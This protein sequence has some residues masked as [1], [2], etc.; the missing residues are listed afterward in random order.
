M[1]ADVQIDPAN[2]GEVLA[3]CGLAVLASRRSPDAVTGFQRKAGHAVFASPDVDVATL[4]TEAGTTTTAVGIGGVALDWWEAWGMN[5][6]MKLWAG[7]KSARTIVRNLGAA[8]E[9]GMN[10]RWLEFAV[11]M[12][13]RLDVD[14]QGTWN[15]LDLGWSV[16]EHDEAAMLCRPFVELLAMV[17]LQEFHLSGSKADGFEYGLWRAAPY[18]VARTAFRGHGHHVVARCGMRTG[19]NG[20]NWTL[21]Y[22][23]V[24]WRPSQ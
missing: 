18:L 5:P 2:P 24:D 20:K 16:N 10:E 7:Q 21:K 17:G 8:T 1:S 6:E 14:P 22:A 4:T 9:K 3:C 13:G 11:P 23:D 12:S 19:R 15:A